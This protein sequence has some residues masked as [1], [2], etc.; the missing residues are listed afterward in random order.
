MARWHRGYLVGLLA[1][2]NALGGCT[3]TSPGEYIK[4]HF[5]IGPNYVVPPAPLEKDWIDADDRRVRKES[6]DLS[7]WWKVFNDPILDDLICFAYKQNLTLREAGY[8]VLYARAQLGIAI[9][10]IMPQTQSITGDYDRI[11]KSIANA[12]SQFIPL[13]YYSQNDYAFNLAWELDFWGK[14]R[15]AIESSK[16]TLEASVADY[17]DVLVTL[18]SDVATNYVQYRVAELRIRYAKENAALQR[19]TVQVVENRMKVGAARQLDVDQARSL[20]YQTEAGIP[21][22]EIGLRQSANAICVLLGIPPEDLQAKLATAPIP[23]APASVGLGIPADL[24][25]RRPDIRRA[26]RQAAAQCALIGVAEADFYPHISLVGN[27]GYSAQHFRDLFLPRSV[28]ATAG[29]TFTWN[30]L[31]YGRIL[32]NVRAQTATF[33]QLV[34]AYQQAVLNAQHEAENGLVIFL[35]AQK[36]TELQTLSVEAAQ[37]AVKTVLSQFEA[38]TVTIAQLILLEQ[39]LVGLQDTLA[40]AQ[41]EIPIGLIQVYKAM[42]GGWELRLNGCEPTG[43]LPVEPLPTPETGPMPRTL[44][45]TERPAVRFLPPIA[46]ADIQSWSQSR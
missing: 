27:I 40:Q 19:R 13:R 9:G 7:K 33:L 22:L 4:N 45:Q 32:N 42:G 3:C 26:E 36:R 30:F 23:V 37:D 34:T 31:V 2:V 17:D 5:K 15:R 28:V 1:V 12:N 46:G 18:L 16:A 43:Q 35:K 29:P 14:F 6:D 8:R 39:T 21:E 20:L 11:T 10:T 44:P 25:R 38:G 24:L 41:G